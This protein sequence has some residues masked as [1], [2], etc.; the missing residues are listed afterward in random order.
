MPEGKRGERK[1][2]VEFIP[3]P[4]KPLIHNQVSTI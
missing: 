2:T 3:L 1:I 4:V